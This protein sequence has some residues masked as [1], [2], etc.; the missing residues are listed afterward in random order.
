MKKARSIMAALVAAGMLASLLGGCG[1]DSSD[2]TTSNDAQSAASSAEYTLAAC[3][4]LTGDNMQYG[5]SYR[6]AINMAVDEFNE[7]GGLDGNPVKVAFYDDKGDQK[8]A[9][10]AANL[11]ASDDS[12]FTVIGSFG[13]SLS[14]AIAPVFEEAQ[15]PLLSPNTSHPDFPDMTT[16]GISTS[17]TSEVD[18]GGFA[19][20]IYERFDGASVAILYQNTDNGVTASDYFTQYYEELGGKVVAAETFLPAQTKDFTPLL[21]KL[22]QVNP[23]ILYVHGDYTDA[24]QAILQ[25]KKVGFDVQ[26]ILPGTI[27]KQEFL[28]VVGTAADGAII[29]SGDTVYLPEVVATSNYSDLLKEFIANYNELYPDTPCDGFAAGAYD[30]ARLALGALSEVGDDPQAIVDYVHSLP[31]EMVSAINPRFEGNT[32]VKDLYF[33]TITDGAFASID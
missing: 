25:A 7:A 2:S 29:V 21:S 24:A 23:D 28:D 10:N 31:I 17:Q 32:Y 15:I 26:I 33:Y 16:M 11:I 19:R 8:E 4:P 27:L 12:V 14:M 1:T 13:S 3:I 18:Q 5:I 20:M 30:C 22:K 9:L 6:N